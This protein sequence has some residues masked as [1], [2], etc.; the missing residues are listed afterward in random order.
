MTTKNAA[1]KVT[2]KS[3]EAHTKTTTHDDGKFIRTAIVCEGGNTGSID[4]VTA[5]GIRLG[6]INISFLPERS[7]VGGEPECL[8]VDVIDVDERYEKRRALAFSNKERKILDVPEG[9]KLV[10]VDFR[11][12]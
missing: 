8:I 4:L 5:D 6:Q 3:R 7:S 1:K 9:G 10:S 12:E 2:Q 11:G